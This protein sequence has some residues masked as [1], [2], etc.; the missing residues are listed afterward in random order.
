MAVFIFYNIQLLPNDDSA[1]VGVQGYKKLFTLLRD[2][3]K[4]KVREKRHL[5]YH[6]NLNKNSY[7]GPYNFFSETG[8]ING[9]FVRY[10][11]TDN[12]SEL[13]TD[14]AIFDHESK[15]N[16]VVVGKKKF[17]FI[18]DAKKHI[19]GIEKN[20]APAE[21]FIKLEE[22]LMY[23]LKDISD[24][25]FPEYTL[26]VNLMSSPN[27]LERI[28]DNAIYYKSVEVN[29]IAPN[30]EDAEDILDEM[31]TSKMQRLLIKGS[32][33][34]ANMSSLPDF[35]KNILPSAQ[36]HGKIKLRYV[37]KI[38]NSTNNETKISSYD[39]EKSPLTFT[40]RTSKSDS[41]ER[42]FLRRCLR[43]AVAF[44]ERKESEQVSHDED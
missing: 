44:L 19:L 24:E 3:N 15:P 37:T 1:E 18:F 13:L 40:L 14:K 30:G 28:L 11:D 42:N 34:G 39:S 41:D 6:F 9:N 5:D 31:R 4:N 2:K 36:T 25:H 33:G 7:I 21:D 17:P 20:A 10:S 23:F 35:I 43:R 12:V 8:A 27:E 16:I 22:I 29:L 32:S 38:P 26:T